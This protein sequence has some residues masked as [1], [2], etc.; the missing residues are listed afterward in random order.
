VRP[1]GTPSSVLPPRRA[2]T[3]R[4]GR[5][6]RPGR[7]KRRV[8]R[9][10]ADDGG[11]QGGAAR[12]IKPLAVG[13]SPLTPVPRQLINAL[14]GQQHGQPH[15]RQRASSPPDRRWPPP[16]RST[17]LTTPPRRRRTF[18]TTARTRSP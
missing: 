8:R 7:G 14:V 3:P 18:E 5:G 2:L 9:L 13:G 17:P 4:P 12:D 6:G 16:P 10:R 11:H 15:A 1:G